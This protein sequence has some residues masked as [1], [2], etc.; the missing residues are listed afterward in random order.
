MCM[1]IPEGRGK[2]DGSH[3]RVEEITVP[4]KISGIAVPIKYFLLGLTKKL[5][6][7]LTP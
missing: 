3:S 5:V 6:L 7:S 2:M 1:G 4:I